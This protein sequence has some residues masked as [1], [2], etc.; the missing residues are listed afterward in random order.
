MRFKRHTPSF[1]FA[2]INYRDFAFGF[3]E[4]LYMPFKDTIYM[5]AV[6]WDV[7]LSYFPKKPTEKIKCVNESVRVVS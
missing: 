7:C 3:L 1:L 4:R 6:N 5:L 2:N